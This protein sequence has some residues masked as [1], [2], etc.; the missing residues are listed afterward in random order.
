MSPVS[1]VFTS[2]FPENIAGADN[3]E[4]AVDVEDPLD[5]AGAA[6]PTQYC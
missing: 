1:S 3:P 6:H 2:E 4:G 5:L